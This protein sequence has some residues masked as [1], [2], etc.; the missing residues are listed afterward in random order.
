[1]SNENHSDEITL[2]ELILSVQDYAKEVFRKW[3]IVGII[4]ALCVAYFFYKHYT[5]IVT[6]P[7]EI[8]FMVEGESGQPAIGGL[9]GQFGLGK[10]NANPIKIQEVARSNSLFER[11]MFT[12]NEKHLLANEVISTYKLDETWAET[13][14]KLE[15]FIFNQAQGLKTDID[16]IAF[17]KLEGLVW[18]GAGNDQ[19][20][21]LK[22][23]YSFDEGIFKI[24]AN[25]EDRQLSKNL[26]TTLYVQVADFFENEILKNKMKALNVLD[27][28]LDSLEVSRINKNAELARFD[29]R[30]L[31]VVSNT[32]KSK[33]NIIQQDLIAI[34]GSYAE[35]LKNKE[36][37]EFNLNSSKALFLQIDKTLEPISGRRSNLKQRLVYGIIVGF[38]FSVLLIGIRR[39][40][41]QAMQED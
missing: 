12:K 36:F 5:H 18:K 21:L 13:N 25:A 8:K 33:R 15:N 3:W 22:I 24:S 14:S 26:A 38:L 32:Y 35:V 7:Y 9:L 28:R 23:N 40:Y 31:G 1:M 17:K 4:T 16:K 30:S 41:L 11:M 2:K 37:A 20:P 10:Q 34:T 27:S 6:Y 19:N 29:D 39:F